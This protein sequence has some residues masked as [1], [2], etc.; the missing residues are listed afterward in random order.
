MKAGSHGTFMF[1]EWKR[2]KVAHH[3]REDA[4]V[5]NA[6][7]QKYTH[8]A[9]DVI[10]KCYLLP[11]VE[12]HLIEAPKIH[13]TDESR[14]WKSRKTRAVDEKAQECAHGR[15]KQRKKIK[16]ALGRPFKV[17]AYL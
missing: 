6:R 2:R 12:E 13:C 14:K 15:A 9:H 11:W 5:D 3:E 17:T 16:D 7:E 1:P 10:K 8:S 4:E